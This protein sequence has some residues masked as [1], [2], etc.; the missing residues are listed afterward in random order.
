MTY[1][2]TSGTLAVTLHG[3]GIVIFRSVTAKDRAASTIPV[4]VPLLDRRARRPLAARDME[5]VKER[6]AAMD[7]SVHAACDKERALMADMDRLKGQRM[8]HVIICFLDVADACGSGEYGE[9][10][11]SAAHGGF[12][13]AA[14][15]AYEA[16]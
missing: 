1:E 13:Q 15:R 16:A 6:I 14:R 4:D 11:W 2:A 9:G 8:Y 7:A 10:A 3:Q 12:R 5:A